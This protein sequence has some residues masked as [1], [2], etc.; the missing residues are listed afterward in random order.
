MNPICTTS[1]HDWQLSPSGT[2]RT[3]CRD[4]CPAIERLV[5]GMW[6]DASPSRKS[7]RAHVPLLPRRGGASRI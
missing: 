1:G 7:L 5:D 3:C 4:Y 6:K 2:F